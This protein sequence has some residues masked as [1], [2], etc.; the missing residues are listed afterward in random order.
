M[1]SV[2][3]IQEDIAST[4]FRQGHVWRGSRVEAEDGGS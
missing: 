2:V 1:P 3:S 4:D